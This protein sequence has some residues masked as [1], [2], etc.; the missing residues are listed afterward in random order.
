[1][2]NNSFNSEELVIPVMKN[3]YTRSKHIVFRFIG[4]VSK[5]NIGELKL[6]QIII[7]GLGGLVSIGVLGLYAYWKINSQKSSAK[8][9]G[10]D[11]E[12]T[13]AP[14][15]PKSSFKGKGSDDEYTSVPDQDSTQDDEHTKLLSSADE[16]TLDLGHNNSKIS[17]RNLAPFDRF[18]LDGS[19]SSS[20]FKSAA[21]AAVQPTLSHTSSYSLTMRLPEFGKLGDY[22][23]EAAILE[24]VDDNEKLK[25]L[26]SETNAAMKVIDDMFLK[27]EA[28][29]HS[30]NKDNDDFYS[31]DDDDNDMPTVDN[32]KKEFESFFESFTEGEKNNFASIIRVRNRDNSNSQLLMEKDDIDYERKNDN[33]IAQSYC[34][35][36]IGVYQILKSQSIT[37]DDRKLIMKYAVYRTL[38]KNSLFT[39]I[40]KRD[41]EETKWSELVSVAKNLSIKSISI[42]P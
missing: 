30:C 37:R 40:M 32:L 10:S 25:R 24:T 33:K 41:L 35:F 7:G 19:S 23:F 22:S 20:D 13:S 16:Q 36:D 3:F 26:Y 34:Y 5:T 18:I 4:P 17:G 6:N 31:S 14:I 27:T 1:M 2:K 39:T 21:M 38:T 11:D 8:D 15:L 12:C 9:K 42:H 28:M 29:N